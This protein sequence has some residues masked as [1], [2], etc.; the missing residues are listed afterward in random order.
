[1][2]SVYSRFLGVCI[3]LIANFLCT[4]SQHTH[5]HS[6]QLFTELECVDPLLSLARPPFAMAD[7][8]ADPPLQA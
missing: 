7:P 8:M 5:S 4:L 2:F 1:M 3:T 6:L